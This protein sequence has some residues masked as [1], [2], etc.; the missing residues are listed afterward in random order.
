MILIVTSG[1]HLE[2]SEVYLWEEFLNEG[3][4]EGNNQLDSFSVYM[5]SAPMPMFLLCLLV[6]RGCTTQ[7]MSFHPQVENQSSLE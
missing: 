2:E 5:F 4:G 6:V 1:N 3:T 7:Y